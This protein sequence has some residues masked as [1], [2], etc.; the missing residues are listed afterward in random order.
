MAKKNEN[1]FENKMNRLK[2]IVS[3]LEKEDINLDESI[4]LYK[5]GLDL[6]KELKSE[7]E[8]FENKINELSENEDE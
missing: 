7:L 8:T 5:E 1:S 2:E 3:L 6:S 4:N